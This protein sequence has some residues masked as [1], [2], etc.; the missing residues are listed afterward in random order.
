M[1]KPVILIVGLGEESDDELV[2]ELLK[3]FSI[4]KCSNLTSADALLATT[5]VNL[6]LM[7]VTNGNLGNLAI[8]RTIKTKYP[9][10]DIL[11]VCGN[12]GNQRIAR[13]FSYG[14]TDAFKLPYQID[15]IVERVNT[16]LKQKEEAKQ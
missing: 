6:I 15:L 4:L 11:L 1:E 14:I 12:I 8:I 3:K 16:L 7:V 2:A 10:I 9:T 13:A 5:I